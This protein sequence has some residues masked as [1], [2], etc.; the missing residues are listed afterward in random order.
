METPWETLPNEIWLKIFSYLEVQDLNR[1]ASI[2]KQ[3]KEYAYDKAVWQKLP[4]N[5][6][7]KQVPIEFIQQIVERGTAFLNLDHTEMLGDQLALLKADQLYFAQ[8]NGLKYLN[9]GFIQENPKEVKKNLMSS[10]TQLEKFGCDFI[11]ESE[12]DVVSQCIRQNSESLKCVE[13]YANLDKSDA[14]VS[15]VKLA[16]AI[17]KC[18]QLEELSLHATLYPEDPASTYNLCKI[19]PQNLKKLQHSFSKIE[20]FKER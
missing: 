14:D 8:P 2:S 1:C 17:N 4:I 5:L 3:F 16:T 20:D 9:L 19:L 6:A 13:I 15:F 10:C 18:Q 7:A 11:Y 12:V